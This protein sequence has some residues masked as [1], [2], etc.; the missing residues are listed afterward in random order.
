MQTILGAGGPVANALTPL[1]SAGGQPVRLIS[2]RPVAATGAV[3]WAGADLKDYP[4]LLNAARGATVLYM[5]AGL[6]YDKA[7]WKAE[8]PVITNNVIRLAKDTGARLIFFDNVYMYGQ[9]PGAMTEATPNNPCSVKGA[10]RAAVA[11]ALLNEAARG[12]IRVSLARA[13]DFY[14]TG[15]T[16]SLFDLMVLA[17]L[18]NGKRAQWIGNPDALHSFTYIPD[19][20]PALAALGAR[21]EADNQI[22]HLPT[23]PAQPVRQLIALA[24][25]RAGA[26]SQ[27]SVISRMLLQAIGLFSQPIRETLEMDYQYRHDYVFDSSKFEQ[28]FGI[29]PTPYAE[30]IAAALQ[31]VKAGS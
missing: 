27:V 7:V 25:G 8:W 14:G 18:A 5:C 24:A 22:W 1:L 23:A 4:A 11:D 12:S 31:A 2:R 29:R 3:Q 10:V 17:R 21:P 26:P 30:G 19:T 6:R 28:A 20:A 15:G 16:N 9:V 13:A